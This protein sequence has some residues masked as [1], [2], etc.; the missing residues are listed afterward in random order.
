MQVAYRPQ[1]RLLCG[2]YGDVRLPVH[3]R[4]GS[5]LAALKGCGDRKGPYQETAST[6]P[7]TA[8][9]GWVRKLRGMKM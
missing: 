6:S 7:L 8:A 5:F 1:T 4:S 2:P 9:V 3:A